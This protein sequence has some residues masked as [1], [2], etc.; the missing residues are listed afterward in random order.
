MTHLISVPLEELRLK[1][2][3]DRYE[4]HQAVMGFYDE[5]LPGAAAERR[6]DANIL[7]RVEEGAAGATVLIQSSAAP[8]NVPYTARTRQFEITA[9]DAGTTIRF[10]VAANA[11]HR[12]GAG[13]TRPVIDIE[14]WLEERFDGAL[15]DV[16]V[17]QHVV[18]VR[19]GKG[20]P[21]RVDTIEGVAVVGD[22]VKLAGQMLSGVGR[23][24][25]FGCGLLT[26]AA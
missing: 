7:F 18:D 16:V 24:K 4:M 9:P 26:V 20:A 25:A 1:D 21:L 22:P 19:R 6:A 8:R 3:G 2:V 17:L 13:G 23:A 10:R 11:V 12:V 15:T 5:R 14:Q